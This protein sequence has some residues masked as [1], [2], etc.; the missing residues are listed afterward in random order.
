[1]HLDATTHLI[2]DSPT[3]QPASGLS[4]AYF[5]NDSTGGISDSD[6]SVSDSQ[7]SSSTY[8]NFE[9]D[10]DMEHSKYSDDFCAILS[11]TSEKTTLSHS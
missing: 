11:D 7:N 1:M 5:T 3:S 8:P 9:I 4:D 10:T 6:A 2:N